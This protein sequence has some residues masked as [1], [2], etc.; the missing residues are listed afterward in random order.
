MGT[1]PKPKRTVTI[2][3]GPH[4]AAVDSF[5]NKEPNANWEKEPNLKL[6]S[7]STSPKEHR[8]DNMCV[9]TLHM[10]AA[11]RNHDGRKES[12]S[13]MPSSASLVNGGNENSEGL[14]GRV[15]SQ[16]GAQSD[17]A[18]LKASENVKSTQLSLEPRGK[19]LVLG[20]RLLKRRRRQSESRRTVPE[21][22]LT[23]TC[24]RLQ[25][26]TALRSLRKPLSFPSA[27]RTLNKREARQRKRHPLRPSEDIS[28]ARV[29]SASIHNTKE[30]PSLV[31]PEQE[32]R[33]QEDLDS[34]SDG[35]SST[36]LLSDSGTPG[37]Q[38]SKV[39]FS[40]GGPQRTDGAAREM[41]QTQRGVC[42]S[43]KEA[44]TM[45]TSSLE[46]CAPSRPERRDAEVQA[47][48]EVHSRSTATSPCHFPAAGPP[49]LCC[50][51]VGRS[52]GPAG[53]CEMHSGSQPAPHPAT[54][55]RSFER[56]RGLR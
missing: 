4:I 50:P 15:L 18:H 31:C 24:R 12:R 19:R 27:G 56:R 8:Q 51:A 10:S 23:E 52:E 42:K 11:N 39:R 14:I 17:L 5:G 6:S 20:A 25:V 34:S 49:K 38:Q 21:S 54:G 13:D 28:G 53:A 41:Q 40:D 33:P 48:V 46:R 9:Q 43:F 26:P 32:S 55:W 35:H 29:T 44:A 45:T 3:M 47:V 2:Q 37:R 7:T 1:I 22:P 36:V 16:S 30:K